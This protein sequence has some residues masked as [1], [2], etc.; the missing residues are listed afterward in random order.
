MRIL[1]FALLA[2]CLSGPVQSATLGE[3]ANMIINPIN[4]TDFEVIEQVQTLPRGFWCGAANYVEV[5]T[6]RS[7]LTPIYLKSPRGPSVTAPGRKGVVFTTSP[8]GLPDVGRMLSVDV[9]TKGQSMQSYQARG[10]CR[11]AFTRATK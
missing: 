9:T 3:E 6:N 2:A 4:E 11:D 5:R 7:N 8:N 10:F 1:S